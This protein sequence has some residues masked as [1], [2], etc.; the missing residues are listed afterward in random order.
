M[1]LVWHGL[2]SFTMS[3]KT[4]DGEAICTINPYQNSTG[5]RFPRTLAADMVLQTHN[6]EDANNA[7]SVESVGERSPILFDSPGEYEVNGIFAYGI[8]APRKDDKEAHQIF[9]IEIERIS[10]AHL[11][12]LNRKLTDAELKQLGD[13]DILLLPVGGGRA[14]DPK[15]ASQVMN[16]VEPRI[17]VPYQYE[18]ANVKE[19][20]GSVEAFCKEVGSQKRE[21]TS[22]LK[23]KRS[24]LP[25]SDMILTV[26]SRE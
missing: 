8:N 15:L 25:E 10:M 23:I 16:Q 11:G 24:Q 26:L 7:S 12:V 2:S 1:Q 17:L 9:R 19:K 4:T 22:K 21:D 20:L 3:T 5:L 14:L 13:I 18:L 6:A